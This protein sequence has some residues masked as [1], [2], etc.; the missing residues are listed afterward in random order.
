MAVAGVVYATTK[1][2]QYFGNTAPLLMLVILVPLYTT[3]V[4]SAPWLWA[5]PFL[6]TFVGGVFA[7]MLE[8]K[9]RKLYLFLAG[10]VVVTQASLCWLSM[11]GIV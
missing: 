2:C 4:V 5:L 6:F 7:D 9:Q 11:A 3:Q 1:R 8:T 10:A